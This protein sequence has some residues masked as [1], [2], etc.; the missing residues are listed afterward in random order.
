MGSRAKRKTTAQIAPTSHPTRI[1]GNWFAEGLI[2][3]GAIVRAAA[4]TVAERNPESQ[5]VYGL[6]ALAVVGD[7]RQSQGDLWVEQTGY[8][9]WTVSLGLDTTRGTALDWQLH[10]KALLLDGDITVRLWTTNALTAGD[11]LVNADTYEDLR[12]YI[13]AGLTAKSWPK[14]STEVIAAR[15]GLE[16][17]DTPSDTDIT[18][19]DEEVR[20]ETS[21]PLDV[22]ETSLKFMCFPRAEGAER[23]WRLGLQ[24][25]SWAEV[26]ITRESERHAVSSHIHVHDAGDPFVNA[27]ATRHAKAFVALLMGIVR[28]RDAGATMVGGAQLV[29][30]EVDDPL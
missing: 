25:D 28:G 20:I 10:L 29:R 30:F 16:V 27:L 18:P 8:W 13:A 24:P 15:R 14:P 6:E 4:A 5:A 2:H 9:E 1:S 23:R 26:A 21:L 19:F 11:E 17:A 22:I 3:V 7:L 12:Q